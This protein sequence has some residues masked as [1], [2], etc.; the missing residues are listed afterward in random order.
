MGQAVP[1]STTARASA[2]PPAANCT[3]SAGIEL[4]IFDIMGG[5]ASRGAAAQPAASIPKTKTIGLLMGIPQQCAKTS[6]KQGQNN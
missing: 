3:H 6:R 2:A 1:L 5:G 4:S